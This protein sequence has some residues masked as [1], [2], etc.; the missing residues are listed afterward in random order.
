LSGLAVLENTIMQM[1]AAPQSQ[2][3]GGQSF[4]ATF[5]SAPGALPAQSMTTG[6]LIARIRA[7]HLSADRLAQ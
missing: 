2:F 5:N 1:V 7:L 4:T 3:V 6:Q